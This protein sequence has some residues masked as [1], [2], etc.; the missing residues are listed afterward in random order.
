MSG[1]PSLT[2]KLPAPVLLVFSR[3]LQAL[4]TPVVALLIATAGGLIERADAVSFCNVLFVGNLCAS[5]VVLASFGPSRIARDLRGLKGLGRVEVFVFGGLSA[6][7]SALIFSALETTTVTNAVLLARLG[8][9]LYA[10]GATLLIGAAL[11]TSEW[12]GFALVALGVLATVFTGAGFEVVTGDVLILGSAVVFAIVQT[13][14]KRLSPQI[15]IAGLV[16]ARNFL[17]AIVFFFIAASLYGWQHFADA[18]YGPLWGIMLVYALIVI[19]AAQ[20]AW[21]AALGRMS[22]AAIARWTVLSPLLAVGY[23]FAI[24]GEVPGVTQLIALGFVTAG[25]LISNLGKA[26]PPPVSDAAESSLAAG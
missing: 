6:L 13:L 1:G 10:L 15:G 14:G 23:A 2:E 18:F 4:A 16:F 24:N 9:V 5:F 11:S 7:L 25:I 19:V 17:S 8:P 21:Y 20:F 26:E 12:A 3:A 22:P